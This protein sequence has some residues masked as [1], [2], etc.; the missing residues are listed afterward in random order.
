[1]NKLTGIRAT[2]TQTFQTLTEDGDTI[3]ITLRFLPAAQYWE[4]DVT[5]GDFEVLGHRLVTALNLFYK[6]KEL[7]PFGILIDTIDGG[8]PFIIDDFTSGRCTM[9][10][11]T[12]DEVADTETA[13]SEFSPYFAE[14]G[15]IDRLVTDQGENILTDIGEVLKVFSTGR[16]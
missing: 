5:Y 13:Y 16:A 3:S 10:I 9:A 2:G 1:M 14:A 8:D 15:Y 11:L 7:I 4:M 12:A 6:F